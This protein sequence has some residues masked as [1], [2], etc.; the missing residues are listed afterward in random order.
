MADEYVLLYERIKSTNYANLV[1]Y[2]NK[3]K[4]GKSKYVT[5]EEKTGVPWYIVGIIDGLEGGFNPKGYLG[6][7][8]KIIGTGKKS[9]LVP[10]NRGPFA[11]WEEGAIDALKY[12]KLHKV[13]SWDLKS[14]L[15]MLSR[16]NGR[17]YELNHRPAGNTLDDRIADALQVNNRCY[18]PYLF[19]LTTV[20]NTGK[21]I[22][23][24][25]FSQFAITKQ[26]G[27][28]IILKSL[29]VFTF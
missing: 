29:G 18:T 14:T 8:E 9:T 2:L 10:K 3:L 4:A 16:Y 6:N 19:G 12:D 7:G 26:S 13:T 21:Y 1:W 5:V 20:H 24:G 17:G 28:A 27:A 15:Y 25:K 22:A 11:T 23:D